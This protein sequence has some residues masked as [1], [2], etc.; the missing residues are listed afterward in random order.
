MYDDVKIGTKIGT[1]IIRIEW[2]RVPYGGLF[3]WVSIIRGS[4]QKK[5]T[6]LKIFRHELK[7]H[8]NNPLRAGTYLWNSHSLLSNG[9]TCLVLSHLDMQWK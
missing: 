1:K 6:T 7:R 2:A 3:S 9:Q 5:L 8:E 4:L